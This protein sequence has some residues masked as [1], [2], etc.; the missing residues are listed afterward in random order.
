MRGKERR[1][2]PGTSTPNGYLPFFNN[3][4]S[5]RDAKKIYVLKG[6]P[7]TGKSTFLGKLGERLLNLGYDVEFLHCSADS[8]SLDG[9][10]LA[11]LGIALVDGTAPHVID[12]NFP[13]A[14]DVIINLGDFWEEEGIRKNKKEIIK[15][16][17]QIKDCYMHAFSHLKIAK[18]YYDEM[19]NIY[20]KA[21]KKLEL[22]KFI[23]DIINVVYKDKTSPFKIPK[24]R[25]MFASS[26]TPEGKVNFVKN[27]FDG[28]EYKYIFTC[29]SSE[30]V[31][32]VIKAI[33]DRA[34]LMG[35]DV[36]EFHCP[37][38]PEK[39][40]HLILPELNMGFVNSKE[41]HIYDKPEGNYECF[42]LDTL[43]DLEIITENKF[44][45][46]E[47]TKL[48]EALDEAVEGMREAKQLHDNL[49]KFYIESMNFEK[50]DEKLEEVYYDILRNL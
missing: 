2:F 15:L 31:Y 25:K 44:L 27:L 37:I 6:G 34:V 16:Q 48:I 39:I 5:W 32:E 1:Y 22:K 23:S 7:G 36:E 18:I 30:I 43:V 12:P 33:K 38:S 3:V 40:D 41:P 4:I 8:N 9:I 14:I 10:Y 19:E 28:L 45:E 11:N 17:E 13:G 21:V 35:Y 49:E 26:I 24:I 47:K 42:N 20:I 46:A 50:I 29:A